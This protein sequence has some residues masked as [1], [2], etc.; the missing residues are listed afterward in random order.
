VAARQLSQIAKN[1]L[2]TA[3]QAPI[4]AA[5]LDVRGRWTDQR[6]LSKSNR[7]RRNYTKRL[8]SDALHPHML[9]HADLREYIAASVLTHCADG[10]SYLGRAF[11]AHLRGDRDCCRHLAY[12]AELRAAMGVLASGGIGVFNDR[13]VVVDARG[14]CHVVK[15]LGT[16]DFTWQALQHWGSTG[17]ARDLVLAAISPG[18]IPLRDWL[19]AFAVLPGGQTA[20]TT[21]WLVTWGLDLKR[22]SEDRD[23]R[24]ESSYRPTA[25]LSPGAPALTDALRFVTEFWQLNDPSGVLAFASLDRHLLRESIAVAFRSM[26]GRNRT[27]LQARQQFKH[28][29][30][31]MLG[32]LGFAPVGLPVDEWQ[33]FLSYEADN[34]PRLLIE[35]AR[36]HARALHL[37]HPRQ[38]MARAA[39]LLR[40][41]SGV[42]RSGLRSLPN[43]NAADLAFWWSAFGEGRCL[44]DCG[45][46]PQDFFDLWADVADALQD[47]EAWRAGLGDQQPSYALLWREQPGSA[48]CLESC[49]RVAL[50]GFGL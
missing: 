18:G 14:R 12:Y 1:L 34:Q 19:S 44:W 20:L 49:E 3:A 21:N 24:N 17:A 9:R 4:E 25:F 42:A 37:D 47:V 28:C 39:L 50:W 48:A 2:N 35:D 38:V 7:Y 6:W 36:S 5:L 41:A 29:V 26:H 43:V 33:T 22:F 23:A 32:N 27:V 46:R 11:H 15:G 13:H 8:R 31:S 30:R 16:H 40:V 10:W 45:D